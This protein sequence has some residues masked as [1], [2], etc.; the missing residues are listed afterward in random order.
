MMNEQYVDY[1]GQEMD[2]DAWD[3]L[4]NKLADGSGQN[5]A[6]PGQTESDRAVSD[7]RGKPNGS[8]LSQSLGSDVPLKSGEA[9][10]IPF[11]GVKRC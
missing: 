5:A 9:W 7:R 2:Q 1:D 6:K 8:R 10:A 4:V 11:D 3:D